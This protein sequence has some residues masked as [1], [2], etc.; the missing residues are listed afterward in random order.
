M[1]AFPI[2]LLTLTTLTDLN[3]SRNDLKTVPETISELS[4]L[5]YL[6]LDN[7]NLSKIPESLCKLTGS[8]ELLL[9]ENLFIFR[10]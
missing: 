2:S 9:G 5:E 8:V 4:G 6:N 10:L 1:T 7:T 3:L